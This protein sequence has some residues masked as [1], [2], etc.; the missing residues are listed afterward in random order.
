M[1]TLHRPRA[2]GDRN[3]GQGER[4]GGGKKEKKKEKK[5][6]SGRKV[7]YERSWKA[8]ARGVKFAG[9]KLSFSYP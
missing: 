3:R 6:K 8:I 4:E 5:K 7:Q 9:K 2:K 1:I